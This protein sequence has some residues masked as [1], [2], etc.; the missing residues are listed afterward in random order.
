MHCCFI[1]INNLMNYL[2]VLLLPH[3]L[4]CCSSF[5][6]QDQYC[7]VKVNTRNHLTNLFHWVSVNVVCQ[8]F[9]QHGIYLIFNSL[10]LHWQTTNQ[11]SNTFLK[12]LK[13]NITAVFW[14]CMH[15]W[16]RG[17]TLK[18]CQKHPLNSESLYWRTDA[19]QTILERENT[20]NLRVVTV[21]SRSRVKIRILNPCLSSKVSFECMWQI[22]SFVFNAS[23]WFSVKR[24]NVSCHWRGDSPA[25]G[26]ISFSWASRVRR[27]KTNAHCGHV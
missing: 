22:V 8:W 19:V 17:D 3:I 5:L 18:F 15:A 12:Q 25:K 7:A 27:Q 13:S 10:T 21:I 24:K 23:C 2:S 1:C 9:D 16:T 14:P 11:L 4:P 20:G 6:F 26:T